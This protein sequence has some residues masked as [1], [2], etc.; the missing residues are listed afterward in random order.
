MDLEQHR[1][2]VEQAR[3]GGAGY[4]RDLAAAEAAVLRGQFNLAKVLRALAHAQRAQAL[5]AA[6]LLDEAHGPAAALHAVAAELAD[7]PPGQTQQQE[8]T[9]ADP[10][11]ER[12]ARFVAARRSAREL[13]A[14]AVTSL[15]AYRDVREEDVTQIVWGCY[16]CGALVEGALPDYC[17]VCGALAAEFE[18]FAPFYIATPEHLGQLAPPELLAILAAVPDQVAAAIGGA[19]EATLRRKPS[20]AEWC[21]KEIIGHMLE[22]DLLFQRAVRTILAGEGLP[23][24]PAATPPWKLHEGK[25]YEALPT[26]ELLTRLRQ[27]RADCLDLIRDLPPEGWVRRGAMRGVTP[28]LIDLGTWLANHDRGHLVQ[29]EQLCQA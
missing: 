23:Q 28:S 13:A 22:T 18:R 19:D 29:I 20:A 27:T 8:A 2:L 9:A 12:L 10:V 26:P 4:V 16:G 7:L 5:A 11:A 25:G 21:A 24:I 3:T 14:R 15:T 6:R 17:P 1:Y